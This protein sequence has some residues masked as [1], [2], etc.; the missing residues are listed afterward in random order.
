MRE[1]HDDAFAIQRA[2]T[3]HCIKRVH[4]A[5]SEGTKRKA[6]SASSIKGADSTAQKL[7]KG[8]EIPKRVRRMAGTILSETSHQHADPLSNTT[9]KAAGRVVLE[10]ENFSDVNIASG[11]FSFSFKFGDK[12]AT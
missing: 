11:E 5:P 1:N 6:I 2:E 9:K 12:K 10:L 8:P 4:F 7:K 3:K